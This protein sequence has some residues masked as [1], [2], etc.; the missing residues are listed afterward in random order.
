MGS[1]LNAVR[2]LVGQGF[3][4]TFHRNPFDPTAL[5]VRLAIDLPRPRDS[6]I[7]LAMTYL[8]PRISEVFNDFEHF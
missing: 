1:T 6:T 5:D 2:L 7:S 4:V 8:T 3:D